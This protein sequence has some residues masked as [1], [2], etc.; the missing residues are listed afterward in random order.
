GRQEDLVIAASGVPV[1]VYP[2]A[3]KTFKE[4]A[5]ET[6]VAKTTAQEIGARSGDA[7]FQAAF[8][9]R[10][11]RGLLAPFGEARLIEFAV[12][13]PGV[14]L[15]FHLHAT[16]D[17]D[18]AACTL[19]YPTELFDDDTAQRLL[20]CFKTMVGEL[21]RG[22]GACLGKVDLLGDEARRAVLQDFNRTE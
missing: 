12:R 21:A 19:D 5:A 7:P 6:A 14:E 16:I 2:S 22:N 17:D 1:R 8:A 9:F 11:A 15:D 10:D 20:T 13:Q 3:K 18:G 4:F